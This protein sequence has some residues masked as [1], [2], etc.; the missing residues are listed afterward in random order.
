MNIKDNLL[1]K[2]NKYDEDIVLYGMKVVG[3]NIITILTIT[4]TAYLT[5]SFIFG[6]IFLCSLAIVRVKIGGIH[7]KTMIRC[8]LSMILIYVT[9]LYISK[10]VTYVMVLNHAAF[11]A[12]IYLIYLLF[13]NQDKLD[14]SSLLIVLLY[15][16]VY[17]GSNKYIFIPVFTGL[18]VGE[19]LYIIKYY[20][21]KK[22]VK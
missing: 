5:D 20:D 2:S 6:C 7:C 19:I 3:F 17:L 4:T 14:F 10:N 16:F 9:V 13:H 1:S 12:I 18:I 21:I 11:L 15:V 22:Y 8:L